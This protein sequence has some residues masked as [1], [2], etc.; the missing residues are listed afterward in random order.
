L[1]LELLVVGFFQ[2]PEQDALR[3]FTFDIFMA[4]RIHA[5]IG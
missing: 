4:E 2:V 5:V 1:L 3:T